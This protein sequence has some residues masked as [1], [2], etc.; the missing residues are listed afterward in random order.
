MNLCLLVFT[1]MVIQAQVTPILDILDPFIH[2]AQMKADYPFCP[3]APLMD[4][5]ARGMAAILMLQVMKLM[6][7][8]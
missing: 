6:L 5:M 3:P 7:N 8:P 4:P 1:I 2:I